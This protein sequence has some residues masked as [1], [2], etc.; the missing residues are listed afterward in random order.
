MGKNKPL[1]VEQ[2]LDAGN[3]F[4][5]LLQADLI[6]SIETASKKTGFSGWYLREL[7]AA[8]KIRHF[9]RNGHQY[10]FYP[11]DIMKLFKTVESVS[12]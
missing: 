1:T 12:R 8:K 11:A 5:E 6:Y 4:E 10:F 2:M 3:T 7:C 9:M